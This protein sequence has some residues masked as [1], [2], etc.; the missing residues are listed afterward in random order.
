MGR[1]RWNMKKR[2]RIGEYI[3]EKSIAGIAF[4]SLACIVLIF[5]FVFREALPIFWGGNAKPA[6][7]ATTA[8]PAA[9]TGASESY[10]DVPGPTQPVG[11]SES[12]GDEPDTTAVKSD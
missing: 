6:Q 8:G 7:V 2:M 11:A 4:A 9:P 1:F 12:Y 5:V 10:G 3:L